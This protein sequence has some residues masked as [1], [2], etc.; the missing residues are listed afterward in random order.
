MMGLERGGGG[1]GDEVRKGGVSQIRKVLEE[2]ESCYK[3][4]ALNVTA[5]QL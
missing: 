3:N 4:K 2:C 1:G 5:N